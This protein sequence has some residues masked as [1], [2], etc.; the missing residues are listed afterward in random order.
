MCLPVQ[1]Q[2]SET[3][4]PQAGHVEVN[5]SIV[6]TDLPNLFATVKN[7]VGNLSPSPSS[8]YVTHDRLIAL[9]TS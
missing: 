1:L 5:A 2:P 4:P 7:D 8:Y 9:S 6:S 3:A